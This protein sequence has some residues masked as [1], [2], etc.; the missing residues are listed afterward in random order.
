MDATA[1]EL[2]SV[3]V[4][5]PVRD[6]LPGIVACVR[7]LLTQ[8]YP[9]DR[10]EIIVVD[11]GSRE[12]LAPHLPTDDRLIVLSEGTAGSYVA[13]NAGIAKAGGEVLAF[14][15]SDCVPT[16]E[17][18][19]R[20]VRA[21]TGDPLVAM[22]GGRVEMTFSGGVPRSGPELYEFANAFPQRSYVEQGGFAVT[23][24]MATWRR[25]FDSVGLF[26]TTLLSGGDAEWGRRLRATGAR[27]VYADDAVVRHPA[28]EEWLQLLAKHRRTAIG[29]IGRL[30]ENRRRP[31]RLIAF[32][33]GHLARATADTVRGLRTGAPRGVGRRPGYLAARWSVAL[34]DAGALLAAVRPALRLPGTR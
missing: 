22:V 5:V 2:P 19:G 11:N 29:V 16:P 26:D 8:N 9:A 13:R 4:V 3:S 15:D 25:E 23:A 28:R 20:M 24:N 12:A 14:T 31:H 34:T 17:W 27:Q 21:L 33:F 10:L 7:A 1:G 6:G 32:A 30:P 18:I